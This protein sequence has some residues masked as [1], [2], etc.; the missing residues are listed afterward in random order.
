MTALN[1]ISETKE[2]QGL[3]VSENLQKQSKSERKSELISKKTPGSFKQWQIPEMIP[4]VDTEVVFFTF[5]V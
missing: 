5:Q 2:H 1:T 3:K 4:K